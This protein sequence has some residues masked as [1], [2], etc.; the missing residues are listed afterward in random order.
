MSLEPTRADGLARLAAFAPLMG[1]AYAQGR[2]GDP[3]PGRRRYVSELSAHIRHRL[4][5]EEEVLRIALAQH[6]LPAAET[7]VQEVFWRVYWKGFL[8]LRPAMWA[9]YRARARAL[10]A[11]LSA[12]AGLRRAFE[13]AAAGATGIA[14]FD[15]W[16]RELAETGY[17]HNHARMWFASIWIFTLRLPW[18]LGAELFLHHLKDADPAS[19]T[20]SWR[21]VGGIQTP[22]KHYLARAENIARYSFGRFDPRGQLIEDAAP[23][24]EPPPPPPGALSDGPAIPRGRVALLLHEEDATFWPEGAEVV[25]VGFL[26]WPQQRSIFGAAA[27]AA[28]FTEAAVADGARLLAARTARGAERLTPDKVGAWARGVGAEAILTPHAPVGWVRPMLEGVERA[29]LPLVAP[30]RAFDTLCWPL[31]RR[32]F[33]AFRRHIPELLRALGLAGHRR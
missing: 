30:R 28:A 19:N 2:N 20:L 15:A 22:G 17:L 29:G 24:A 26:C 5:T 27:A 16:A 8:E 32:G 14:C 7:F 21:W 6:G 10:Q 9:E 31:A 33:F 18:V 1:R 12:Q 25:G 4:V 11:E 23:L 3:G 13:A